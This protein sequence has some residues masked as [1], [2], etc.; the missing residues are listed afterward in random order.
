MSAEHSR[1][2][3]PP[4]VAGAA[5]DEEA[6]DESRR[7]QPGPHTLE[8]LR[9]QGLISEDEYRARKSGEKTMDRGG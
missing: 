6:G 2:A 9:E 7:P 1:T 5:S 8:G 3:D 4:P